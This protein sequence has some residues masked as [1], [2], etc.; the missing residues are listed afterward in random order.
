MDAW[1][2]SKRQLAALLREPAPDGNWVAMLE[3]AAQR[4]LALARRDT[5][6]ALYLLIQTAVSETARYSSHHAILCAVVCEQCATW[7]GWSAD[8]I[9]SLVRA[10]LTMNISMSAMQDALALHSGPL[11][12]AQRQEI[13]GHASASAALLATAGVT[14]A[15]WLDVVREHHRA[16]TA[17][18]DQPPPAALRLAELLRRVDIYTAKLSRRASR[19]ATT[20]SIAARDACL[21]A[22]GAPDA[23]GATILRMLG[24]YPPGSFVLLANGEVGIVIRRG[25]KAH[26]PIVSLLKRADGRLSTQPLHRDTSIHLYA[27]THGLSARDVNVRVPHER[28]LGR[29][30]SKA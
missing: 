3:S 6:T 20:P 15:L 16:A 12:E 22:T 7:L 11:S 27:V 14:E 18:T 4:M 23:I 25:A 2:L 19:E 1:D 10:A 8:E 17:H 30:T 9:H 13:A 28:M 26:T 24:L 21:D 5:D 29:R